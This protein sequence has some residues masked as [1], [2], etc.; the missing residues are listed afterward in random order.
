MRP[1][2]KGREKLIVRKV[3][4]S[5]LKLGDLILYKIDNQL[6]CHRLVKKSRTNN[7]Y[8][9]YSRGDAS[10][11]TPELIKEQLFLGKVVSIIKENKVINLEGI[12]QEFINR[13]SVFFLPLLNFMIRLCYRP[14]SF[15]RTAYR[16]PHIAK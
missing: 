5:D 16:K 8:L 13:I 15:I 9:I 12:R 11:G 4:V 10:S 2:L 6:V 7:G 1:F 3:A 14:F